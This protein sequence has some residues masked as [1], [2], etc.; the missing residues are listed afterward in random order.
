[1]HGHRSFN[2]K[3]VALEKGKN[4]TVHLNGKLN[5]IDR[6]GNGFYKKGKLQ[7]VN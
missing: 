1:M 4:G 5:G 7:Q 3:M 6:N 2:F